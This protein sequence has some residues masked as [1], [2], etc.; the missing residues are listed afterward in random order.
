MAKAKRR[1]AGLYTLETMRLLYSR[2]TE[3][4]RPKGGVRIEFD[5]GSWVGYSCEMADSFARGECGGFDS[6]HRV[7][8]AAIAR[9]EPRGCATFDRSELRDMLGISS[10]ATTN[11]IRNAKERGLILAESDAREVWIAADHAQRGV[12]ARWQSESTDLLSVEGDPEW[13]TRHFEEA[14]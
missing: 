12:S 6:A 14:S 5:S 4:K 11:A 13:I 10:Q 3:A 7:Y 9:L 1:P 8:F 2:P